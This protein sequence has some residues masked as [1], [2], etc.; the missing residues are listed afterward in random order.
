MGV[1]VDSRKE[2]SFLLKIGLA[3]K[4]LKT[5]CWLTPKRQVGHIHSSKEFKNLSGGS[6]FE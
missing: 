5:D 4:G 1:L 6:I 3:L 2:T